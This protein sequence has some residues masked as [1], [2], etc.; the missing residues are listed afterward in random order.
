MACSLAEFGGQ[1]RGTG[2]RPSAF[3]T[4]TLETSRGSTGA[5]VRSMTAGGVAVCRTLGSSFDPVLNSGFSRVGIDLGGSLDDGRFHSRKPGLLS[6]RSRGSALIGGSALTG[7]VGRVSGMLS[8]G[9]VG[10]PP[11]R[12]TIRRLG[13]ES[14]E[15][16]TSTAPRD[17][18]QCASFPAKSRQRTAPGDR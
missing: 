7:I 10:L 8:V 2:S 15:V 13:L 6:A 9:I 12:S 11:A 18:S 5:A 16:V 14:C 1:R 4:V 3:A 17:R